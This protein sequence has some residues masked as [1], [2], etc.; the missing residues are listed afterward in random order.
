MRSGCPV[1]VVS[2][3]EGRQRKRTVRDRSTASAPSPPPF[4]HVRRPAILLLLFLLPGRKNEMDCAHRG[5][6]PSKWLGRSLTPSRMEDSHYEQGRSDHGWMPAVSSEGNRGIRSFS[7]RG[8]LCA[9]LLRIKNRD[10]KRGVPARKESR[11][12]HRCFALRQDSEPIR[13]PDRN[14]LPK[15]S[16]RPTSHKPCSF[17]AFSRG[18]CPRHFFPSTTDRIS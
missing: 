12:G 5:P 10:K 17:E 6:S 1:I 14:P 3:V 9:K 13:I 4:S 18:H 2:A 7:T 16:H 8:K 15:T 11:G